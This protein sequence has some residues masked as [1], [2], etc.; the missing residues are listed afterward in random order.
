[1]HLFVRIKGRLK[2][3]EITFTDADEPDKLEFNGEV[4]GD[5]I[6]GTSKARGGAQYTWRAVREK[7][8]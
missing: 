8:P 2:G 7:Q 5:I 3:N 4:K 6:E 1:M